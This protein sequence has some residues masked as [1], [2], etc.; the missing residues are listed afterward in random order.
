MA[1]LD[2]HAQFEA[3]G[4]IAELHGLPRVATHN[5]KGTLTAGYLVPGQL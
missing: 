2:S 4:L 3:F 1:V 5:W